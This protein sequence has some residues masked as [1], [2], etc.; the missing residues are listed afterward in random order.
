MNPQ[1]RETLDYIMERLD[2]HE[3]EWPGVE[4]FVP[5]EGR[6]IWGLLPEDVYTALVQL[7]TLLL[8]EEG[9]DV[10]YEEEE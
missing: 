6:G 1:I 7:N 3:G 5:A 10:E 8:E 9:H 4:V 2:M